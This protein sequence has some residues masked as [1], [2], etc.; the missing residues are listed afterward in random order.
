MGVPRRRAKTR[1]RPQSRPQEMQTMDRDSG[2]R[3]PLTAAI[4][5]ALA[6]L[7]VAVGA[8]Y[9]FNEMRSI[10]EMPP[11]PPPSTEWTTAPEGG[12]EVDL[13]ETPMTNVPPPSPR[14]EPAP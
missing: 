9:Y 10:R 12:V 3:G 14:P 8:W 7:A 6:G 2:S 5:L 1:F 13:P 11:P 4:I